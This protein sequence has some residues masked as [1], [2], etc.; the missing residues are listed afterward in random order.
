MVKIIITVT[1]IPTLKLNSVLL[2]SIQL[3]GV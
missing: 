2:L 3:S 1:I